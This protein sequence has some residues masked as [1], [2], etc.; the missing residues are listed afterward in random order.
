MGKKGSE[1]PGEGAGKEEGWRGLF[2]GLK[3]KQRKRG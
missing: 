3:S 2:S 1:L